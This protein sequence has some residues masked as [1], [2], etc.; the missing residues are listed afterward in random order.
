MIII[1]FHG[2]LETD[3]LKWNQVEKGEKK[4]SEHL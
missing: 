1:Y 4:M 2:T 3:F